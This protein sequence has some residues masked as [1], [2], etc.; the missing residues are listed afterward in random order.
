[1][2][3]PPDK[4]NVSQHFAFSVIVQKGRNYVITSFLSLPGQPPWQLGW[5]DLP[6]GHALVLGLCLSQPQRKSLHRP[7][8]AQQ[9][10]K[11]KY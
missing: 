5:A 8:S 3:N 9:C 4:V 11:I 7:H 6:R 1:M 10:E 2:K